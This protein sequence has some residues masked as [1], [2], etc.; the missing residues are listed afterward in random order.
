MIFIVV[1]HINS[2]MNKI[3]KAKGYGIIESIH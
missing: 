1:K 3:K 2:E